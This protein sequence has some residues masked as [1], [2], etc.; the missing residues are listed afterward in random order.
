MAIKELQ[1]RIALKYD[2]YDNWKNSEL[3]LLPGEIG[4]C[5]IPDGSDQATNN[6]TV[7]FKIGDGHTP[8]K[9][10]KWA[11]ALAADVYGWAKASDV[12]YNQE[13]KTITFVGAKNEDGSDKVFT[14]NYVTA[15]EVA[16]LMSETVQ[17]VAENKGKLDKL[18][19]TGEDSLAAKLAAIENA[20]TQADQGITD[21]IGD[22]GDGTVAAAIE[23]AKA[24]A[25]ADAE[26]KVDALANGQVK[27]NTA[28]IAD[29]LSKLN[30]EAKDRKDAD[31][32]L[33]RRLDKVETFFNAAGEEEGY[34][35]LNKA[36]DTLVEIQTYLTGDGQEAGDVISRIAAAEDAIDDLE[37]EFNTDGRVTVAEQNIADLTKEFNTDTGRV[38]VAESEI[39]ALQAIVAG[40]SGAEAIKNAIEAVQDDVDNLDEILNTP[41][42]GLVA[43]INNST[44]GLNATYQLAYA[45][46]E[47]ANTNKQDIAEIQRDYLTKA[48]EYIL[49]CGSATK[50]VHEAPE[51]PDNA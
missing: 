17:T 16:S 27:T 51:T 26:G 4:I 8:Y 34:D 6:P 47:Q 39:D 19:G 18:L 31:D 12:V 35:G 3:V 28:D 29:L 23:A 11:S 22:V 42:T 21:K 14:F 43:L 46:N 36:L 44:T 25:I 49:N 9:D 2:S 20:Y 1:T 13:A 10:L 24:A 30:T 50:V 38:K 32:E 5:T 40:Y 15:E 41:D 33:D 48:D 7:L 45:A 37:A